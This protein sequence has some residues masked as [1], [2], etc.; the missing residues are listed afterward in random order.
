MRH[1]PPGTPHPTYVQHRVDDKHGART[2]AAR[3]PAVEHLSTDP[4]VQTRRRRPHTVLLAGQGAP[5]QDQRSETRSTLSIPHH[6]SS[7]EGPGRRLRRPRP[8]PYAVP[9]VL[10][11]QPPGTR[12]GSAGRL[13]KSGTEEARHSG[14]AAPES[15]SCPRCHAPPRRPPGPLSSSV[16]HRRGTPPGCTSA[17]R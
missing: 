2:R 9:S 6:S 15:D 10:D 8:P 4:Q 3:P 14:P 17:M 1:L 7:G 12:G 5:E 16:A 13:V 11:P